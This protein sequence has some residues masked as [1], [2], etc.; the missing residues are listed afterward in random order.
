MSRYKVGE[1]SIETFVRGTSTLLRIP[2]PKISY[3]TSHLATDTMLGVV[4]PVSNTLFLKSRKADFAAYYV[5][6]HELRHSWQWRSHKDFY[7][8][9]YKTRD[10]CA[11]LDEYNLQ[12]A[13]IDANAFSKVILSFYFGLTPTFETLSDAA[14]TKISKRADELAMFWT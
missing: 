1:V 5:I 3:D 8:R 6:A 10:E 11:T 12:A 14:R 9:S 4:E 2:Q 13:E 7:F